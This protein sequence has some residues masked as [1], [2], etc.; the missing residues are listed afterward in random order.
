M[1]QLFSVNVLHDPDVIT[2]FITIDDL[3]T[4][5]RVLQHFEEKDS[6]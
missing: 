5:K 3:D 1:T 4:I 2:Y 6:G